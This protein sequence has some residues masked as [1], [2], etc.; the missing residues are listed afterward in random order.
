MGA[1]PPP[2]RLNPV[3][4]VWTFLAAKPSAVWEFLAFGA[5]S[6]VLLAALA[7]LYRTGG[8]DARSVSKD[9]LLLLLVLAFFGVFLD[10]LQTAA[11]QSYHFD[12]SRN[13]FIV[14]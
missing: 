1:A 3:A 9:M 11:G 8:A 4:A 5:A 2:S 14:V 7:L 6:A 12:R 10:L 13:G